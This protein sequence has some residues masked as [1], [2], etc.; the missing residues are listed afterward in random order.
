MEKS[1][2]TPNCST[3]ESAWVMSVSYTHLGQDGGI[4]LQEALLV[5]IGANLLQDLAALDEGIPVSYTHL[6]DP[7]GITATLY[8][9]GQQRVIC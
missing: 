5:Q 7:D 2:V 8:P 6:D 9:A 4:H 3:V 1:I